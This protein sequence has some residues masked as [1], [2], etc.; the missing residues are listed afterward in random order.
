MALNLLENK[1][2]EYIQ[3]HLVRL[4]MKLTRVL[5]LCLALAMLFAGLWADEIRSVDPLILPVW[6][7]TSP[8]NGR[9]PGTVNN[10]ANAG[11][12]AL[13]LAKTMKY[14]A[15]PTYGVG[16]VSYVDD[17]YGPINQ[18]FT[19]ELAWDN[20]SNTLPFQ[21]TFRFIFL[22]GASIYT[23]YEQDYSTSSLT[24]VQNALINFFQYD[25][26]MQYR[27]RADNTNF[28]WKS[29]IR[30]ELDAARPVIYSVV[31][32][33]GVEVAFVID[34]YNDEGLFHANWSNADYPDSWV[35]LN[36]LSV[37]GQAIP[38]NSQYMLTGVRP[39][40]GP[41]NIDENFETDFSNFNWQFSGHANWT[42]STEAA[43][44]GTQSA[45]SGNINDN[46]TTSMFIQIN[47]TQ[48]DTISFY[49][50][51]S[52]EAEPNNLYDHMAFLI[53]GVEQ[54]RWSGD[55]QWQYHEYPVSAGVHEFRWTYNKDGASDYFGDCAWVD[56]ID[57]P[58]G[59]TPLNPPLFTEA[60]LV[61]A[62]DI[63][64]NWAPPSGTN[65]TLQG[66]KIYR[67][68]VLL[69][70][71]SN[72]AMTSY[73]DYNLPNGDYTYQVRA[74]YTE[75][76]SG[77]GNPTTVTV[78]VPYAPTNLSATLSGINTAHLQWS[79][80]PM[81]RDRV[82]M[83]YMVY[84]DNALIAQ[85][86]NPEALEYNDPGLPEG[87]YFY[88]VSAMWQTGESARSNIAQLAVGVPEPPANLQAVVAGNMVTLS[89]NQVPETE[90]L[91]GFKVFRN[92]LAIA[93]IDVPTQL[94][95]T[96]SNLRN[97]AYAYYVRAIYGDTESGNSA[98]VNV[99]V[100]VPYPPVNVVAT[101]NGDDVQ[102]TWSNPELVRSLT[103]YFIYRNGQ[104]IAAVFNPNTTIYTDLNLANGIYTY[105]ISAV[106][107]GTESAQSAPVNA[108]VEVLYPP[109]GLTANV[110]LADV[111]LHWTLPVN[112]GGLRALNGF[113]V[114]QN[115]ALV[116]YLPGS[117]V[118]SYT[119]VNVPNGL[120]IYKVTAVYGMGESTPAV[121][122]NV[123]VEVLYP[124][125]VLNA[126]AQ[127]DDVLLSWTAAPTSPGR[128]LAASRSF[129]NYNVYRGGNLITQTTDLNYTDPDLA[130]GVYQ[131]Y[132]TVAYGTG[133][134]I[135]SPTAT[136][137]VEVLY[138]PTALI[139]NV[140]GDD[141]A[142]SWTA[143]V[144]SG[145]LG[146]GF[147]GY[148]VF[149]D[150]S[151]L[152]NTPEA[153]YVDA[154]LPNGSYE[155][156]VYAVY[157]G[158]VSQPTNTVQALV[159]V[160][161]PPSNLSRTVTDHND[162]NLHWTAA[163]VSG[164]NRAFV[165][166]QVYRNDVML[167]VT[168]ELDY[169]DPDLADG[170]YDYYIRAAYD[171]GVSD[172]T[173]TVHAFIEYPYPPA[174]L[175]A[176]VA[177]DAVNLTW[178]AVPGTNVQYRLHRDGILIAGLAGTSY[179]D[180]GL[181]N[182]TYQY[183]LQSFNAS[184][185]GISDPCPSVS[186]TVD[187]PYPPRNLTG[188][189]TADS[190]TLQWNAPATGPRTLVN[191]QVY[192]D[193]SLIG[194]SV[195]PVYVD[196]GLANATYSYYVTAQYDNAESV[197][198]NM[199]VLMV[200]VLYPP[201][202]L[203]HVVNG[204]DVT[205]SWTAAVTSGGLR[206]LQSYRVFRDGVQIA[207]TTGTAYTD[208]N[209]ANGSYQYYV[210][211]E[212]L[213]GVS[214][215]TNTVTAIVE[216]LYPPSGLS[217]TTDDDSIILS[218]QPAATAGGLRGF[219]GY[220]LYRDGAL[221]AT[222]PGTGYTD[223]GLA[224]G[225]Y[226]YYVTASYDSGESSASNT[227]TVNL[228]VLYP[229][230]GLV[231]LVTGDDVSLSWTAAAT[232]GGLRSLLGYKVLRDGAVIATTALLNY[233]DMDLANGIYQYQIVASYDSG[234]SA[235]TPMVEAMVEVLYPP[236]G[237]TYSVNAD[238][239]TLSW[240]A[241]PV[242]A[243]AMQGY[244]I[245]RDG[246]YIATSSATT[247]T[248]SGLANG[249]YQYY[250][251]AIY[252]TGESTPTNTVTATVEVLYPASNLT[253]LVS[254]DD[255]TLSWNAAATSGGLRSFQSY[256]IYRD[257][258]LI[259][260]TAALTYTDLN[261][262]NGTYQ[263]YVVA[264]Y[265]S[266]ISTPTNTVTVMVEVLYPPTALTHVVN[267]D[268]V[269]LSW[270]AAVT[271]GGLR[272]LQ[273][274]RVFRD[275]VQ[276]AQTTGTAYTDLNL[277]N[278]SYQYYVQ[279][280]YLTGVSAPT[281]TV[282]A[283]V[284][285]LYPPSGLSYTTD[286]DSIILSWQ[287]AATAGGLRGF[288]GYKLYRDG[289][290]LAT[291]PGTGYTDAGLANGIY[292]YYVT[293]SYDS[294]E[295]SASNTVTVNL[296]VLYPATGLVAL[297]TG[298]DVSLSWN[299]A[300]TSGGLR[301]LLG[302]KVLRDGA[303]IT[304]TALVNYQDMD[305]ANGI[306]QYQ[307]V[308]SYDSGDSAPTP[309]VEAM[310][311][312]LYPPSGLTYS[313]NADAV[314]LSWTA[315]PV[316]ARAMQGYKVY[317]DGQYIATSSA[318]TYTDSG[319][320]NG[321]YQYQV[322]AIYTTGESTHTNTVTATVEVLYPASNLTYVVNDDDVTLSWNAAATSGGLRSFQSYAIYRDGALIG[323][324]AALTYTDL[325]LA[326]GTYQYY[327][328]AV[329]DSGTSTPTNTVTVM[330]EVL[331]PPTALTHVVNGDDVTLS[332]TAAVTS[333]GLRYLQSYRV[334]RDGI[335]IAQTTGTTYTDMNLANGSY[336][337]YVQA[338]YLTG[339]SAPTNTVT[340]IVE[341]LYPPS[342]LTA[343]VIADDV[344][345]SWT[346][347]A[348]GG[349][350]I[351]GYKAYRDG[352]EIAQT[353]GTSYTDANLANGTFSYYVTALYD[354]GESLPTNTEAVT[355][356]V[357]YAVTN[358]SA[359]VNA[360]A[361]SLTWTIPATAPQ[362]AFLGYFIYRNNA[363]R[364]VLSDPSQSA[365]TDSGLANGQY[366]YYLV[367]IYSGG[368][369]LPS[370]VVNVEINVMPD[371]P[372]PTGLSATL[373]GERDVLLAWNVP[374]PNVLQYLVFRNGI[375]IASTTTASYTDA[376]LPNGSY[377]Y[378]VKAEYAEGLSSASET[379]IVNIM[380]ASPPT[381]LS[382]AVQS[383]KNV[384]LSW[385]LP[386][387]GEIGLIVYR[388]GTELTF[389]TDSSQTQYLDQNLA[390]GTYVYSVAAVYLGVISTPGTSATANILVPYAPQGLQLAVNANAVSLNWQAP[391]DLGGFTIY[392]I[393]R[394]GSLLAQTAQ[395][396]YTDPGLPNGSYQYS[397]TAMYGILESLPT[398]PQTA[399]IGIA[400][401][402]GTLS[403]SV[404]AD[405]V[406]LSW[407]AVSDP[408]GFLAYDVW[409]NGALAA[410]VSGTS[411]TDAN[412]PNGD[413]SY[414]ITGRYT[415]GSSAPTNTA[416][417]SVEVLYAPTGLTYNVVDNDVF[418]SW[419]AAPNSASGRSLLGYKVFRG[420]VQIG[421]VP[422]TTYTDQDLSNGTYQY[423]VVASYSTGDSAP[424]NTVNVLMEVLYPAAN[425]VR[426]VSSDDVYLSWDAVPASGA[427]L[428][429]Y[430]VYRNGQVIAQTSQ[431]AYNDLSLPNGSYTWWVTAQYT[432][433]ESLPTN[434]V[435][436]VI[437]I[438]YGVTDLAYSVDTDDV[439][440]TWS[441][442]PNSDRA[443]IGYQ[444]YRNDV[445]IAAQTQTGYQDLNLPNGNYNYYII[446]VYD[447]GASSPSN[448]VTA[449][450]FVL[451][452]PTNLMANYQTHNSVRLNWTA[453]NQMELG[454]LI[455]R[456]DTQ[457]ATISDPATTTYLD[458]LLPN[459]MYTYY[460]VAQYPLAI[461]PPSNTASIDITT[462][463]PPRDLVAIPS[464]TQI[465]YGWLP[466]LETY[467]LH[468]YWVYITRNGD[469]FM[470]Q[471]IPSSQTTFQV[472]NLSNATYAAWITSI[473]GAENLQSAPSNTETTTIVIPYAPTGVTAE[474]QNGNNVSLQW[475]APNQLETGF[476][477]Y[478]NDTQIAVISNPATSN[479]MDNAVP[480]GIYNYYVKAVYSNVN[481]PA[482]NTASVT[483]VLPYPPQNLTV[484]VSG[485]S[486]TLDWD[487]PVDTFG[488]SNYYI[489][490]YQAGVFIWGEISIPNT[491]THTQT[492]P[493]GAWDMDVK[494]IYQPGELMSGPS[495][496]VHADILAAY[497]PTGLLGIV[498][499]NDVSLSWSAPGDAG[500]LTSYSVYRD[501]AV[502]ATLNQ[503]TYV[504]A[505]LA[506]GAYTYV[507]RSNYGAQQSG[508]SNSQIMEVLVSYSPQNLTG[509]TE[510][511][512]VN[513]AWEPVTDTYGW[514]SYAVLRD[515][516]IIATPVE[517]QYQDASLANGTY[518][519]TV[520]A[521]YAFG[522]SAPSNIYTA[523]ID[524]PYPAVELQV[525]VAGN[526]V[527][528]TWNPPQDVTFLTGFSLY[529]GG[530]LLAQMQNPGYQ[531]TNLPNG[532]YSY[533]VI[534]N[535][536]DLASEPT[537]TQTAHVEVIYPP[538]QLVAGV[539]AGTVTLTWTPVA[540]AGYF[541]RYRI[542]R[543][544]E[545]VA[546][547]QDPTF[548]DESLDNGA[549]QYQV[550][551]M[552]QS[553]ES[554]ATQE[555]VATILVPRAPLN[556]LATKVD[557]SITITWEAPGHG[558]IPDHYAVWYLMDGEQETPDEWN[559][560][561]VVD[562]V[563]TLILTVDGGYLEGDYLFA[564][565]ALYGELESS[566]AFSN[567]VHMEAPTPPAPTVNKLVGNYPNPFNPQT[568]IVFWLK[569]PN[570]IRLSIYNERGQEV[571]KLY[572]ATLAAGEYVVPWDGLDDN[573]RPLSSG[574][575]FC[576]MTGKGIDKV[577][578]M[579]LL[580]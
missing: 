13:A 53:D 158:G 98:T 101:V 204:D 47:V 265:D 279:A 337:Y 331:Y 366:S 65:P 71:Y 125:A 339:V 81:L 146:R 303:V 43:F 286:D 544:G 473:F 205:L 15:Y 520:K 217:Y 333:G 428:L 93:T 290:L 33:S 344:N 142:L 559:P 14:W 88:E 145:G 122:N 267:G 538:T 277:A 280:E 64:V 528:I 154:N 221:L 1:P 194:S 83:G 485:S 565:Q 539:N 443:L 269:T 175:A 117:G 505:D 362:R 114:Y 188:Q 480:N 70:Q 176:N 531:D 227:V 516:A 313:V 324:T 230:T 130:N 546:T 153:S 576:R 281:N 57:L 34:G 404:S 309:M 40:Q 412:L 213:T 464:G 126:E 152:N 465:S 67:N 422:G 120:Y 49:K 479:Y 36:A 447:A 107:S 504:D 90:F 23:N 212:Y 249:V 215:P 106:Y 262:A 191:Y 390:N 445:Q 541:Q 119:H 455:F 172:P 325:N 360:D 571:R 406:T 35:D 137:E 92:G 244:K 425:L 437:E 139:A 318:T 9:C 211:A 359:Q 48:A 500:G 434:T 577:H 173:N 136:V 335:Q 226:Q 411:H 216:V 202:A 238:A 478:R 525:A 393:Y 45:K 135:P 46:Q 235:P 12:H 86:E 322:T 327:V 5:I 340:A 50:K 148:R 253:Y 373:S 549:Y 231:A 440:L 564:V 543:N 332:W 195:M 197:A 510:D 438:T 284:E 329:Y 164:R 206:D 77:P 193:G 224:N 89:W 342:G 490:Y 27:N 526:D 317:R 68:A 121:V 423:H 99:V 457:I 181:A 537:A 282:T 511:M 312:V 558:A 128:D 294:G 552:Y 487:V 296:E 275:G 96:D 509:I 568:R 270:T 69:L 198:S 168:A 278:G 518:Q 178:N 255:V 554:S 94:G 170:Q 272:D 382:A 18:V 397:I 256:A 555:A 55:G 87:V 330:V 536:G 314:T 156:L 171:T 398:A 63:Q 129:L 458:Q 501:A 73:V 574:V 283:I 385:T 208:L 268:D 470:L 371:L 37:N 534:A 376:N 165:G 214:A 237:L 540:D 460:V 32:Q 430:K 26:T 345:L 472:Q 149:R 161:Y 169:S 421:M 483:V 3:T 414:Q 184:D 127:D 399:D 58:E 508:D 201:T 415:F 310:V 375:Q 378:H 484:Q 365:W 372:P 111:S 453:P 503:T 298:D 334:F 364:E 24:N 177:G 323:N 179:V 182:G 305:L 112:Q 431:T 186:A 39:S 486:V 384:L 6:H 424:T 355:I 572:K 301:S 475:T 61:G 410:S 519:Y 481:S 459:A 304:T 271:S 535:Y 209:L 492:L 566:V 273:S 494:A 580:K 166:Y 524:H 352:T 266:G 100:E 113:N 245:Y 548:T 417:A 133:T 80:P 302:Y 357:L 416:S 380:V 402:P 29:L 489:S 274:Y 432:S 228:E 134:S 499:A 477:V 347:S 8:W 109:T 403:A 183:F 495:N 306:Y 320:A 346:A 514:I 336:Q 258:A 527:T 276:I 367:A 91:T 54:Q 11:S 515:E 468:H 551:A 95:Y 433:G 210:Q 396:N 132:I 247:Y 7:Q 234:D 542:Y 579:L 389:I 21:T 248:D 358:L 356:E 502:I 469:P 196:A 395:T 368:L 513:L 102:L 328:V 44:F 351:N 151:L 104:I 263:Y 38:N 448:T 545:P 4:L 289:A 370:N 167:G 241:A 462:P 295:S 192:R 379:A 225:I 243:R 450:V 160:L 155:Y 561:E 493:N 51:I 497:P 573:G 52:C 259:G 297:V 349:R 575:Y 420:S 300:A 394:N 62:N 124:V 321:V 550:T 2:E 74:V 116:A 76:I 341:V 288:M 190:V 115:N 570:T 28:Y 250:V 418:L 391:A 363:L 118:N 140:N 260:N 85:V 369:S 199:V 97:G 163:P 350:A 560:M 374:S 426:I 307:I 476:I 147:I 220:K 444:I 381:N 348:T 452:P 219:M 482:S 185:S 316:S 578:K 442:P 293:A 264:V 326:N 413:Y 222:V 144:N 251:T 496:Q 157:A 233:Q 354:S 240:T 41:P 10:R 223:A 138:P 174:G 522:D 292:Q 353:T 252:T 59:T 232:S 20:M 315:A 429:N 463:Y 218:W 512:D 203:T 110:S 521:F 407:G 257:G 491:T 474:I 180:A 456:N 82:L 569:A 466:P 75:G 557:Y 308:A 427:T 408:G 84:R 439:T 533:Y 229:A 103:H 401:M 387:Q 246:Q 285:V 19:N 159:E 392:R 377:S 311:E 78:E 498:D 66:Y 400:Y 123:L 141:V 343:S 42:I 553:G 207:Q 108:L 131:Y 488:I 556:A 22:C 79:A 471:E 31:M 338:E 562:S 547:T 467:G 461:S 187:V 319:L 454:Y 563:A 419:T 30:T 200:E 261:L 405:D 25:P 287:P 239:V 150:G 523:T 446:V 236:S 383:G 189:V 254:D 162:V 567:I 530:Q 388:N 435:Q 299:A 506:N 17:D 56:A 105:R 517:P 507:V 361:V 386:N 72:P 291:V 532:E 441:A 143:P 409:R 242:S 436:A 60:E 16:S 449:P 451:F 529:R